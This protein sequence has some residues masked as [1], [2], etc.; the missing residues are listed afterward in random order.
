MTKIKDADELSRLWHE[1]VTLNEIADHFSMTR[2]GIMAAA[3]RFGLPSRGR[4]K[5]GSNRVRPVVIRGEYFES[6]ADAARDLDV[7]ETAIS[8]ARRRGR[9]DS[10]GLRDK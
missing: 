1:N 10:V 3:K 6:Q 8:Q 5:G 7:S 4:P 2:S 9:L